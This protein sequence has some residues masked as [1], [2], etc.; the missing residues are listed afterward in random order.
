MITGRIRESSTRYKQWLEVLGTPE[1]P[2]ESP[3]AHV[4]IFPGVGEARCYKVAVSRLSPAQLGRLVA[5]I[6]GKFQIPADEV[7]ASL[8][9]RQGLP[10]LADD[11]DV[12]IDLR[13]FA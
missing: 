3:N 6:S 1:V 2:L 7:M 13:A 12:S 5:F 8:L 4:G 11:V 9:G 10:V